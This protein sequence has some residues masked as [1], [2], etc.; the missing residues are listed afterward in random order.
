MIFKRHILTEKYPNCLL[1]NII[2]R[3]YHHSDKQEYGKVMECVEME[4]KFYEKYYN[5]D[6][7]KCGFDYPH[8]FHE[9]TNMD[10]KV[11]IRIEMILKMVI[12]KEQFEYL[13]RE[14]TGIIQ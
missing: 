10:K 12:E 9:E 6:I 14:L 3:K 2:K 7:R 1:V 4:A 11:N 8:E 5:I 13:Q